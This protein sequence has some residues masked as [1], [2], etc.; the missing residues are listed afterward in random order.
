KIQASPT[1]RSKQP[2]VSIGS[3]HVDIVQ[4]HVDWKRAQALNRIDQKQASMARAYLPYFSEVYS[5]PTQVLHEAD[6]KNSGAFAR[7][8][9]F[10]EAIENRQPAD[11]HAA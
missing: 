10:I 1:L 7:L 6:S 4:M 9:D 11:L 5:V 8:L 3:E 2:F